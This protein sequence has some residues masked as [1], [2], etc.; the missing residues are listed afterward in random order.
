MRWPHLVSLTAL[1]LSSTPGVRGDVAGSKDPGWSEPEPAQAFAA[2]D[3]SG[4]PYPAFYRLYIRPHAVLEEG[5]VWCA[6]QDGEGRPLVTAYDAQSRRWS[7]PVRASQHGL[8]ADT[9]GN[10]SLCLDRN[11]HLHVFF[12]CHGR[13]MYHVRSVRPYDLTAWQPMPHPTERATYPQTMRMADGRILLFYRAG[14]HMEP[15]SMRISEDD[16]ATWSEPERVV[17]M[18]REPPDRMAA[19]YC[20]FH[21]GADHNTVHG[22]FVHKDDNPTRVDPHPWRPL[23]YPG[24]HEAVYRYNIYYLVRDAEGTWR[25]GDGTKLPL[26]VSKATAD[27]LARV[28]DTGHEFARPRRVVIDAENR[29]YIRFSEGVSDWT[30]GRV[31]VPH[32]RRYATLR[33]GQWQVTPEV[34]G[35]W[36]ADVGRLI[37]TPG[38]PV[39]GVGRPSPWFIFEKRGLSEHG[40]ATYVFLHHLQHGYATRDGGPAWPPANAPGESNPKRKP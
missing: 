29:P 5:R 26:P 3:R 22:F 11:G 8:G 15:W 32:K 33:D 2:L 34:P 24:L 39:A 27:R 9:H 25:A 4:R 19:A 12:G 37:N 23:K 10:P 21:P 38:D 40:R 18:R 1:L 17:E 31:I 7:G 28:Y 16:G 35:T 6:Y 36:P 30:T 13:R 14:G 20:T